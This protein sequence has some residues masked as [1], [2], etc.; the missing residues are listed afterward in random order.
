M[1]KDSDGVMCLDLLTCLSPA[2]LPF[3]CV[4]SSVCIG[5]R[6][7]DTMAIPEMTKGKI[8]TSR[9]LLLDGMANKR[10]KMTTGQNG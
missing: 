3:V 6:I 1:E 9:E 8:E 4:F 7:W 5:N 10:N 2:S